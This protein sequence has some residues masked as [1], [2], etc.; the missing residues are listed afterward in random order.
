[1]K[2]IIKV[3]CPECKGILEIDV[4][5]QKVLAH[6]HTL[7]D[8]ATEKDKDALFEEVVDR[9]KSKHAEG[10]ALFDK[11]KESVERNDERLDQ[12]FGEMQKKIEDAKDADDLGEDPKRIFW[13]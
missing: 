3:K 6:K 9:V 5:S 11:V 4:A 7:R 13:D 1:M 12:L 2:S 8:D 10:D